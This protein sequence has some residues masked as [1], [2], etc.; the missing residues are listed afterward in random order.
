[1][2]HLVLNFRVLIFILFSMRSDQTKGSSVSVNALSRKYWHVQFVKRIQ[3]AGQR[4]LVDKASDQDGFWPL[5]SYA[6][7][8]DLHPPNP[9][10]HSGIQASL[11]SYS[12]NRRPIHRQARRFF[13]LGHEYFSIGSSPALAISAYQWD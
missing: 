12:V 6:D 5:I 13:F 4:G 9:V 3:N 7:F 10:R 2:I 1:M 11:Y 8:G